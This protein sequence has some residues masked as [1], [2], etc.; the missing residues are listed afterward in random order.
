[1][2]GNKTKLSLVI[3]ALLTSPAALSADEKHGF[4]AAIGGGSV[5][6]YGGMTLYDFTYRYQFTP[7]WGAEIGYSLFQSEVWTSV[8]YGV[9]EQYT[10]DNSYA[11]R[12][13]A[14]YTYQVSPRHSIIFKAG[15]GQAEANYERH[16]YDHDNDQLVLLDEYSDDG[17]GIYTALGWRCR[18]FSGFEILSSVAYQNSGP[19]EM[20]NITFG[21]GYSF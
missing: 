2:L 18:F 1:M 19:F 21:F 3:L 14:T 6:K 9:A 15:L 8:I 11:T 12:L 4:S 10:L 7:D 13:A 16:D 20:T 5:A 17:Y